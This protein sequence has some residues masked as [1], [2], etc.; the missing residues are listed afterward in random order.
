MKKI[1]IFL[2]F[3][4]FVGFLQ[5]QTVV[6]N[7]TQKTP[8]VVLLDILIKKDTIL[9]TNYNQGTFTTIGSHSPAYLFKDM[10]DYR[11]YL[12]KYK[13][14]F[15]IVEEEL[16]GYVLIK[17]TITKEGYAHFNF[18]SSFDKRAEMMV[19]DIV[20]GMKGW[21]PAMNE[22]GEPIEAEGYL[23]AFFDIEAKKHQIERHI[24][25]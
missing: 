17:F 2:S 14:F 15:Y 8:L 10:K 19:K 11:E 22:K 12:R 9:I 3:F 16:K 13:S 24:D 21:T 18:V 6:E 25:K 20:L 5:A 4:M 23:V 1:F 7:F